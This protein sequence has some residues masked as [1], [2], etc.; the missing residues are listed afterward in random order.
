MTD[1]AYGI[2]FDEDDAAA[3]GRWLDD[4]ELKVYPHFAKRGYSRNTALQ[5]YSLNAPLEVIITREGL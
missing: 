5:V 2:D 1:D 4:F 3:L